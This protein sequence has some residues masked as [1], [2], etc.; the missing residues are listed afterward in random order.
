MANTD[1]NNKAAEAVAL[2]QKNFDDASEVLNT[3]PEDATEEQKAEAVKAVNEAKE[4]L[5]KA[6]M[7][8]VKKD[9]KEKKLKFKV[10]PTGKFGLA[11]NVGES[12]AFNEAQANELVESGYA[13]FVK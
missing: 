11:Y 1:K 12:G 5:D 7:E 13:E 4:A 10:S 6:T 9:T 2:L 8:P 3:L